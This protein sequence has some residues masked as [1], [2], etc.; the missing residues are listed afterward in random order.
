VEEQFKFLLPPHKAGA[1]IG[2]A[3]RERGWR[4]AP[5]PEGAL[6]TTTWVGLLLMDDFLNFF[7]INFSSHRT[8]G[9]GDNN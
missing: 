7:I 8:K 3:C 2:P 6:S 4:A 1:H 5:A 9:W